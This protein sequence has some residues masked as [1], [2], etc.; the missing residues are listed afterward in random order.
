MA[1]RFAVSCYL[2]EQVFQALLLGTF[3]V[4]ALLLAAAGLYASLSLA[5]GRRSRELGI[6]MALGAAR[7]GVLRMVVLQ[8]MRVAAVGLVVGVAGAL[9]LNRVLEAFLFEV[10][11]ADP[12]TL[13]GVALLLGVVAAAASVLPARRATAVDP[14]TVLRAE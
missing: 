11:P 8:G 5:V 9:A 7:A 1:V 6:R 13:L 4:V 14:V 2:Q 3:S 10:E 12:V